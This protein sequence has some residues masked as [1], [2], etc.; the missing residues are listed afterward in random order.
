MQPYAKVDA[1]HA[2][3]HDPEKRA[4]RQYKSHAMEGLPIGVQVVGRRGESVSRYGESK[5][6]SKG[7]G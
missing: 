3:Q 7:A 1:V 5:D 2:S 4:Y 6:S